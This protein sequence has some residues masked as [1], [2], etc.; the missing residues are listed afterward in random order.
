MRG[1]VTTH[2]YI[3]VFGNICLILIIKQRD[4][5]CEGSKLYI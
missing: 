1:K 3:N 4:I 5:N 2:F